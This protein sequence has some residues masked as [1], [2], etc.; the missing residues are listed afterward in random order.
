MGARELAQRWH[1][2]LISGARLPGVPVERPDP[3]T[4]RRAP[5]RPAAAEPRRCGPFEAVT[6]FAEL[7]D[8]L[9]RRVD[10]ALNTAG[11]SQDT[12]AAA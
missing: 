11:D 2:R 3:I 6:Q 12:V 1:S 5:P 7:I 10:L 8:S 4:P 9:A